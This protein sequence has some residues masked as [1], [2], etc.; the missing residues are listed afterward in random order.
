MICGEKMYHRARGFNFDIL[1][2][3]DVFKTKISRMMNFIMK[4]GTP[5]R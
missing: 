1:I 2:A 5:S 3:R 4:E